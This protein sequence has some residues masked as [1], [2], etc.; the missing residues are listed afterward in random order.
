[1]RSMGLKG[2]LG[3][4][5]PQ[6]LASLLNGEAQLLLRL[7]YFLALPAHLSLPLDWTVFGLS[8]AHHGESSRSMPE[9]HGN[10]AK[11]ALAPPTTSR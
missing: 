10:R 9:L 8:C 2:S 5:F 6:A 7:P 4:T 11:K 1:M 3:S